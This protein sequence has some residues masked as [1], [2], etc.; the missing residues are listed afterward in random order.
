[1]SAVSAGATVIGIVDGYFEYVAPVWHKEILYALSSGCTVLGAASMG[2]LRA[3]E[4]AAFGMRGIGRIFEDYREGVRTFLEP[5][6]AHH[7]K[8]AAFV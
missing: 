2:A 1:M 7:S 5:T 6:A 8:L 4:C 3:C